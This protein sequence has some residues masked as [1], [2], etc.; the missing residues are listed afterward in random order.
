MT[1][2]ILLLVLTSLMAISASVK[3]EQIVYLNA[4]KLFVDPYEPTMISDYQQ[5]VVCWVDRSTVAA[6]CN[7][8][9]DLVSIGTRQR[10]T[11]TS[12]G[13]IRQIA[14]TPDRKKIVF[15]RVITRDRSGEDYLIGL[16]NIATGSI[17][18]ITRLL[19]CNLR[20]MVITGNSVYFLLTTG[21]EDMRSWL[22]ALDLNKPGR[23]L[24][25]VLS[26]SEDIWCSVCQ[27]GPVSII[28]GSYHPGGNF[29]EASGFFWAEI[30]Q[31]KPRLTRHFVGSFDSLSRIV[32][33]CILPDARLMFGVR[34]FQGEN[35][36]DSLYTL[37]TMTG[38][39]TRLTTGYGPDA[40]R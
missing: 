20:D 6:I 21:S 13:N 18:T 9:I 34:G 38:A 30:D 27:N 39:L 35:V 29:Q 33:S 36:T 16:L 2:S 4:G 17:S 11:V 24:R 28:L 14:V 1:R 32:G 7:G 3:A 25:L 22:K 23:Q 15:A 8:N 40:I 37:N 10:K 26:S 19:D 31:Q 12:F 5:I